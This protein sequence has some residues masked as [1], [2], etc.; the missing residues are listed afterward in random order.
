MCNLEKKIL[1]EFNC[2]AVLHLTIEIVYVILQRITAATVAEI[3]Q[4]SQTV[5]SLCLSVKDNEF[6]FKPGQW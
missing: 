3:S 4:L 5:K 2:A 6:T 1:C